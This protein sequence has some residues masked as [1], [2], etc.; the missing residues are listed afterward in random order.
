V[1]ETEVSVLGKVSL[2]ADALY[3][4]RQGMRQVA[5][6]DSAV[7]QYMGHLP[8]KV[9]SKTGTAQRG[10]NKNDNRLFVCAAPYN[11]PEIVISVAIEPDDD[12]PKDNAHGSSYACI[13]AAR[14]LEEYYN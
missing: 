5:M 3:A 13:A 8:V 12:I 14:V 9:G 4:S 11:D 2:S 1:Y 7:S 6:Y 10:A